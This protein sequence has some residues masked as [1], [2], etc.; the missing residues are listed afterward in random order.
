MKAERRWSGAGCRV[1]RQAERNLM[2]L[3]RLRQLRR[4]E[5]VRLRSWMV[6]VDQHPALVVRSVQGVV[7]VCAARLHLLLLLVGGLAADTA[8][9]VVLA[10]AQIDHVYGG[11]WGRGK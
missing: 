10:R 5:N 11:R 9:I 6:D 3:D 8:A 4:Q 2:R 1:K 7:G